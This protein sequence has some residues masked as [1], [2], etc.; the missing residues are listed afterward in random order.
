MTGTGHKMQDHRAFFINVD[1]FPEEV[2]V[3]AL[4]E[5]ITSGGNGGST[6]ARPTASG[7]SGRPKATKPGH[8]TTSIY[9]GR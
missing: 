3:E 4:D 2:I 5:V 6:S 7:G 8:V 9:S 1:G